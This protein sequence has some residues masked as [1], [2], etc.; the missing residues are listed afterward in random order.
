M[1]ISR[2][3]NAL[4]KTLCT[5]NRFSLSKSQVGWRRQGQ[6]GEPGSEQPGDEDWRNT[7]TYLCKPQ[8]AR[9][10]LLWQKDAVGLVPP[11]KLSS[12]ASGPDH[13][14]N[15]EHLTH[16]S[17]SMEFGCGLYVNTNGHIIIILITNVGSHE[18]AHLIIAT[19]LLQQE[20]ATMRHISLTFPINKWESKTQRS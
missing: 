7:H 9:G 12:W 6:V 13:A 17:G 4:L 15:L 8:A 16:D 10:G 1:F 11:S 3:V 5:R 20:K 19:T 14:L 18:S 2:Q